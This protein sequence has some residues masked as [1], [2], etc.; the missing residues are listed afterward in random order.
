MFVNLSGYLTLE[1]SLCGVNIIAVNSAKDFVCSLAVLR[2]FYL[3][4]QK[5]DGTMYING[6]VQQSR[7]HVCRVIVCLEILHVYALVI[8]KRDCNIYVILCAGI[9]NVKVKSLPQFSGFIIW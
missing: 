6:N 9:R 2:K 4:L 8:D 7:G 5:K 1:N 3:K